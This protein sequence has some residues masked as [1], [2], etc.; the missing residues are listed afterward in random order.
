MSDQS[1]GF[2]G[3]IGRAIAEQKAGGSVEEPVTSNAGESVSGEEG[4]DILFAGDSTN[5]E[6][7]HVDSEDTPSDSVEQKADVPA[8]QNAEAAKP[9]TSTKEI[10][11]V[12]DETGK[13]RK[14][15]I[16]WNDKE[17]IKK[18]LSLS[19]GARKWQAERDQA[20]Q[21]E[22]QLAAKHSEVS[23][24]WNTLEQ[25]FSTSGV[26]G[27]VDLLEGRKGAYKDSVRKQMERE[28]FL[29]EAS[30]AEI[31]ALQEREEAELTRRDLEKLRQE[32]EKFKQEITQERET[33]ELRNLE[34]RVHPAFHKYRF[35]DKLGNEADEH[36]FDE[37]LWNTTL[38]RLEPYEE[39]GLDISPELVEKEFATVSSA[40]RRR[41][42]QQAEKKV[43]RSVQQ[44]KQEATENVQAKIMSGYMEGGA[45]K[46]ARDLINSG[47]TKGLLKNWSK[48]S[49]LFNGKK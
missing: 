27:L 24:N 43:V 38:K 21:R 45:A 15:E 13:R 44:K 16:D 35:A 46:E 49:S 4:T 33:A 11:T 5:E 26:E 40:I 1:S 10:I 3:S 8:G 20:I 17:K 42:G 47:N 39:Q 29:A 25:A 12:T 48:Y 18:D 36:M 37:M 32:N 6:V 41:I 28:K 31:K 30:P 7:L 9:S 2:M 34:A 14:V 19:Y 23:N 22:K